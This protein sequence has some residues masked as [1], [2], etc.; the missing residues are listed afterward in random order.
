MFSKCG[1]LRRIYP[2][3][4]ID[5]VSFRLRTYF[6]VFNGLLSVWFDSTKRESINVGISWILAI[7]HRL[8]STWVER[9][10]CDIFTERFASIC[11]LRGQ[12]S[13]LSC[14]K[15]LHAGRFRCSTI[16]GIPSKR[17]RLYHDD[18]GLK[19]KLTSIPHFPFH[20]SSEWT[21]TSLHEYSA[22]IEAFCR[23]ILAVRQI[24]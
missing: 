19:V 6:L 24:F 7:K 18:Q 21:V 12:H 1:E 11:C 2:V 14:P 13:K 23:L 17:L 22:N 16:L 5:F 20:T 10:I 8:Y 4:K 15:A 9:T 3:S